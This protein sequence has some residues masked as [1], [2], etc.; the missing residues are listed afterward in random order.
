MTENLK[1]F[2]GPR[3]FN[4][5]LTFERDEIGVAQGIAWTE[6]GGEV[7]AIEVLLTA[8]TGAAKQT[9]NL[10]PVMKELLEIKHASR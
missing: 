3:R 4:R 1:D 6:A 2:L 10:G 8:G 9:G 7:L 5:D